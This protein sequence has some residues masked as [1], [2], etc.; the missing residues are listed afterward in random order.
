MQAAYI[1]RRGER[2]F[3]AYDANQIAVEPILASFIQMQQGV[4]R[5]STPLFAQLVAGFVANC[6]TTTVATAS[7]TTFINS[8]TTTGELTTNNI[9][10]FARRIED[11]VLSLRLRPNQQFAVIT[12]ID[13]SGDSNYH[14]AQFTLRRR[15][16]SGLGVSLAYTF[17]KSIDNQSVDPV[18]ATSGGAINNTTSRAPVD[19]RDFRLDRGRSDFDRTHILQGAT[20]WEVPV[21]KGKRFLKSSSGI[22]NQILGGWTVNSIFA[23]MTGEPFNVNAGGDSSSAPGGRTANAAHTARALVQ[24]PISAHLQYLP[25]QTS[26]G[27]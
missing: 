22:V 7:A 12:K 27:P 3:M 17:A 2:L 4:T 9:G 20:V 15:F 8:S 18:G 26:I 14:A 19:I 21:G 24:R 25:G 6:Q 13:N 10:N 16:T 1:G 23:F 5:T 11:S